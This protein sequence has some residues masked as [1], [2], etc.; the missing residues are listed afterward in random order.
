MTY[1]GIPPFLLHLHAATQHTRYMQSQ[2]RQ[3]I[4]LLIH[5]DYFLFLF[6]SVPLVIFLFMSYTRNDLPVQ[7]ICTERELVNT[8]AILSKVN[9]VLK[10]P[11]LDTKLPLQ[12][13]TIIAVL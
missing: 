10:L 5:T 4:L 13:A 9:I 1:N 7:L 11:K 6:F 2:V 12:L 3:P 8:K